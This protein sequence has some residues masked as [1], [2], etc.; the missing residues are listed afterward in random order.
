[1]IFEEIFTKEY[2]LKIYPN[3][4]NSISYL[5][6]NLKDDSNLELNL[7]DNNGSKVELIFSGLA[8]IGGNK[9]AISTSNL[10][11]GA[12]YVEII[13]NGIKLRYKLL[14]EK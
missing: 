1:M 9:F 8:L 6:F 11:S 4:T 14:V 7:L 10:S 2:E 13:V 5:E 3:P 12:Y